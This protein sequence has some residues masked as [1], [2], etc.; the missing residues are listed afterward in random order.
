MRLQSA[1]FDMDGTLLDSMPM[2]QELGVSLLGRFGVEADAELQERLK[3]MTL[4]QGAA[5]CRETYH[6]EPTVE[7]LVALLEQRVDHFYHNEVQAKP[8]VAR[9]LSLLKM[10]GVWMYVA[11]A[12]DRHLAEAALRHA[13][14]NGYFRGLVTSAEVG[15]GKDNPEIFERAMRRLRSNKKDTVVFEDSLHAIRTAK[16]AGF[17]VAGVYDA[18]S[19][20]QQ[21]E[22]RSLADY[23][24]RSFDEMFETT[25]LE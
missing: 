11:T 18:S 7:E 15:S 22:I 5:Y 1:I 2:W 14:I 16:A 4:R 20:A 25:A 13:G 21:E 19:E 3:P 23:Y 24:I 10:E 8:G 6:L 9:F 12:T 17:R